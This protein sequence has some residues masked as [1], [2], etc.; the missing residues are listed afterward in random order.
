MAA[1]KNAG[2]GQLEE[3]SD[4]GCGFAALGE[5]FQYAEFNGVEFPSFAAFGWRVFSV[6]ARLVISRM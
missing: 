2:H 4:I 3:S 5:T 6:F 1:F